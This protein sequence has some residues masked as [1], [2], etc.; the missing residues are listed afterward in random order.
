VKNIY[1][2]FLAALIVSCSSNNSSSDAIQSDLDGSLQVDNIIPQAPSINNFVDEV[3]DKQWILSA[4][5]DSTG[6]RFPVFQESNFQFT[7]FLS[8]EIVQFFDLN[9]VP[10]TQ[11]FG[12]NVCNGQSYAGAYRL[13]N[14]VLEI[15]GIAQ[16]DGGCTRSSEIQAQVFGQVLGSD[17]PVMLSLVDGLLL[18]TTGDNLELEFGQQSGTTSEGEEIT[19]YFNRFLLESSWYIDSYRDSA[20]KVTE[21]PREAEWQMVFNESEDRDMPVM[22]LLFGPCVFAYKE[23]YTHDVDIRTQGE[24]QSPGITCDAIAQIVLDDLER[25]VLDTFSSSTSFFAIVQDSSFMTLE[26]SG[27]S[28]SLSLALQSTRF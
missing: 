13:N 4:V 22:N 6:E 15:L 25:S 1:L 10:E 11:V 3:L 18:M 12:Y 24:L 7:M 2:I 20:G 26:T 21:I 9:N 8:S 17:V 23:Y 16:D 19:T 14:N 28:L 5:R 27:G